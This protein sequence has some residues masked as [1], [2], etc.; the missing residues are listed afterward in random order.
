MIKTGDLVAAYL[1]TGRT[2][3]RPEEWVFG[4]YV[5]DEELLAL[6]PAQNRFKVYWLDSFSYTHEDQAAINRYRNNYL[7]NY[8]KILKSM[9]RRKKEA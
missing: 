7:K 2:W 1:W 6:A 8:K 3:R 4:V 9:N 5:G